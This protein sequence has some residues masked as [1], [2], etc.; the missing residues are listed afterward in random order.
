MR[1]SFCLANKI[2]PPCSSEKVVT[3]AY[4]QVIE[5]G[6]TRCVADANLD[7]ASQNALK[8]KAGMSAFIKQYG[9]HYVSRAT[10]GSCLTIHFVLTRTQQKQSKNS[11]SLF[12]FGVRYLTAGFGAAWASKLRTDLAKEHFNLQIFWTAVGVS[13]GAKG[14]STAVSPEDIPVSQE[15]AADEAQPRSS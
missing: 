7:S 3:F 13:K 4:V 8:G 15:E 12:D 14:L 6:E 1:D 5:S 9:S 11:Q 10:L 2:A